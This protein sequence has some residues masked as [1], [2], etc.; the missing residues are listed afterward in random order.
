MGST[1]TCGKFVA[2]Y[3]NHRGESIYVLFEQTYEKNCY[4][5]T[6]RWSCIH[7]GTVG[8]ALK[9]IFISASA[10]EGGMLQNRNGYIT[11]EGY[12]DG[13]IKAFSK[14]YRMGDLPIKLS[15]GKGYSVPVPEGSKDKVQAILRRHGQDK[16]CD[17]LDAGESYYLSL[18]RD[19]DLIVELLN[20]TLP[21]WRLF[22]NGAMPI[23]SPVE[24]S[25]AFVPARNIPDCAVKQK[26]ALK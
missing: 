25:L 18:F 4:P 16:V 11:P 1:V 26:Y 21:A 3:W 9:K 14:V 20:G 22:S 13:W 5:H 2:G 12:I 8:D 7:I 6:P 17:L 19:S 15:V 24:P 23:D 10:C